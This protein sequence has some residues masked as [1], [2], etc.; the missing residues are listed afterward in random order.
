MKKIVKWILA[1]VALLY[2]CLCGL[3]YFSQ[4]K[5]LFNSVKLTKD[6]VFK[7][8]NVFGERF[9]TMQDNQKLYG[10]LF[11]AAASKGLILWFPGGRGMIDSIGI[12]AHLYTDLNYDL[13]V[14]NYRGFG[15]SEG[16]ISSE[17]QFNR[18]MQSVYDYFRGEYA[19]DRIVIF[20]YSLGTG[21]AA[22]LAV[23]NN[24]RM[25]ILQAPYYSMNESAQKVFP[26]LPVK[27]LQ[28]YKFQTYECIDKIK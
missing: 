11:K 12:D 6:H 28:K 21:P 16:I 27:L 8:A 25:L 24:P 5:I 20:G 22:A 3:F 9:I 2:I 14:L 13:F 10:V 7:F 18:D 23:S 4:E 15:K 17:K 26:Y 1:I 19:E